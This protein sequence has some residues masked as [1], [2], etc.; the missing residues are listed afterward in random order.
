MVAG[1]DAFGFSGYDYPDHTVIDVQDDPSLDVG[2]SDFSIDLWVRQTGVD[3][4][5]NG[6]NTIIDKR[7]PFNGL[8]GYVIF[9]Q[10]GKPSIQ[11]NDG[12]GYTN[13]SSSTYI[14][15]G[16]W[17]HLIFT[18]DRDNPTGGGVFY[19]DGVAIS[20]LSIPQYTP[21]RLTMQAAL[22][23]AGVKISMPIG[24]VIWTV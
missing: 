5:N 4:D 10:D 13:F 6:V 19:I 24:L 12:D 2:T 16:K 17:H 18:V 22:E 21:G 20:A 1:D 11:L 8:L 7:D 15:D 3:V 14:N 9:S 23:L